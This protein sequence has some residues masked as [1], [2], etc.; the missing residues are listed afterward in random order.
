MELSETVKKLNAEF[1]KLPGIG[2]KTAERLVYSLL[3]SKNQLAASLA[4][5]LNEMVEKV[6]LCKECGGITEKDPCLICSSD[7]RDRSTVCVVEQPLDIALLERTGSYK[8]LYHV[9]MGTLSPIDGIGPE[10]LRIKEL[11]E[12]IKKDGIKEIIVATNPT[13]GGEATALYI[14]KIMRPLGVTITRIAR[15]VPVG[16]DLEYVDEVTL[17]K[18]LEG[19][20]E[21]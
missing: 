16:S 20:R 11:T 4:K 1:Q 8:G 18:A 5:A 7:K 13:T 2:R 21:I 6:I 10:S 14:S 9:L 12:R 17:V 3:K 19:R 15:G